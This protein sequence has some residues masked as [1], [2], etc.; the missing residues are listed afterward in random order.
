MGHHFTRTKIAV[1]KYFFNGK[2]KKKV[3]ERP[4]NWPKLGTGL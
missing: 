1:I 3:P 2:R 4:S